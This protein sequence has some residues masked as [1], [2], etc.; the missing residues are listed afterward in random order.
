LSLQ[1]RDIPGDNGLPLA[2]VPW[3]IVLLAAS[4]VYES[5]F[6]SGT[7]DAEGMLPLTESQQQDLI[8]LCSQ[9]PNEVWLSAQGDLRP[10]WMF[11]DDARLSVDRR[12]ADAMACLDYSDDTHWGLGPGA[13]AADESIVRADTGQSAHALLAQLKQS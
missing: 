4:S 11:T 13:P 10:I 3:E 8:R 7:S 6:L 12:A 5:T 2:H 9:R 1:L